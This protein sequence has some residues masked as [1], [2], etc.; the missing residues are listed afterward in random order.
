M[1]LFSV[2]R[3][4]VKLSCRA[5]G[6]AGGAAPSWLLIHGLNTNL[7]FWHPL[8]VR[9]L[10]AARQVLL[11][12]QRGHGNSDTPPHGYTTVDLAQDALAVLDSRQVAQADLVAHSFGAGVALQLARLFPERVRSVTLLD[13]RI[14]SIQPDV[15][16]GQWAHFPR[17]SQK[18]AEA[19]IALDPEWKVDCLLPMKLQNADVARV[20]E[21]LEA[22][23]FF[24]PKVQVR[25]ATKYRQLMNETTAVREFDEVGGLTREVLRA[26]PCPTLLVY[27]TVSPFFPSGAELA[28][29]IPQAELIILEGAGHNFPLNQPERTWQTLSAWHGLAGDPTHSSSSELPSSSERS[30]PLDPGG[31]G[32]LPRT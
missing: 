29:E 8:L 1:A 20:G 25:A 11:Y 22:D 3:A 23:G 13:G 12:D 31:R 9:R 24:V 28:R 6:A 17:W 19:G 2:E 18:F 27:G 21:G 16:L 15:R 32:R 30:L 14:R 4:G 7:A 10:S 26:L 5:A